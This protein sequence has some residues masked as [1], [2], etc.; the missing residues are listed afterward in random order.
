MS[1]INL[2]TIV[3]RLV[4]DPEARIVPSGVAVSSFCLA[5]NHRYQDKNKQWQEECAFVPCAAFGRNAEQLA[6]K[7]KGDTVLVHGRL[8]TE[9]WQ[10]EGATHTRLVLITENL[11]FIQPLSKSAAAGSPVQSEPIPEEAG[12]SVPF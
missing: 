10:K 6:Q 7:H 8:R 5:V 12:K 3:G 2:T 9:S 1:D 4:R 11:Q